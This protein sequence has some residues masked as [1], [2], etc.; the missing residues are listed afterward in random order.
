MT[1]TETTIEIHGE[2]LC[3]MPQRAIYWERTRTLFVAD[4]HLGRAATTEQDLARLTDVLQSTGAN[5]V[6][7]L[8]HLLDEGDKVAVAALVAWRAA[9]ASLKV[10]WVHD[11]DDAPDTDLLRT[12]DVVAVAGPTHGPLFVLSHQ[13]MAVRADAYGLCGALHPA[14]VRVGQQVPCFWFQERVGVL[15][16]FGSDVPLRGVEPHDDDRVYAIADGTVGE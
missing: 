10:M 2:T 7:V 16:A 4:A 8:G 5:K 15:P 12:L 11:A 1:S 13:P 9:W 3:L 6:I 14:V